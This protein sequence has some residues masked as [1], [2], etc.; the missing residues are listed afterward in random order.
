MLGRFFKLFCALFIFTIM[1]APGAARAAVTGSSLTTNHWKQGTAE[2][3]SLTATVTSENPPLAEM[4]ISGPQIAA[5]VALTSNQAGTVYTQTI[6]LA[7]RPQVGDAYTVQ[8]NY[9]TDPP[10]SETVKLTVSAVVDNFATLTAPL[11]G[12]AGTANPTFT[13]QAPALAGL[14][15]YRLS[16]KGLDETPWLSAQLSAGT[17]S[18]QYQSTG[19]FPT[20]LTKGVLYDWYLYAFDSL[21]NSSEN[22]DGTVMIGANISGT[23]TDLSGAPVSGAT[24]S[25][26]YAT[27][28]DVVPTSATT[29]ADGSYFLGGL[30]STN[31]RLQFS[32]GGKTFYYNNRLGPLEDSD[33]LLVSAI[34]LKTGIDAKL[35]WGAISGKVVN[36]T[37]TILSGVRVEL[38]YENG[39]ATS[40]PAATSKS[41]GTFAF[42]LIPPGTYRIRVIGTPL[43]YTDLNN[44]ISIDV[45]EGD[46]SAF[47][48]AVLNTVPKVN[49]TGT[50]TDLSGAPLAG[51]WVYP[52]FTSGD[53]A[54]GSGFQTGADGSYAISGLGIGDYKVKFSPLSG[55]GY[56][57]QFYNRKATLLQSD[58]ITVANINTPVTGINAVLGNGRP[59]ITGFT[60]PATSSSL[61]VSGITLTATEETYG[62]AGY[63]I[64]ES[65]TAPLATASGWT[66]SAPT[67]YTF[68][69]VGE[70]TLYAWAKGAT[71]LVSASFARSVSVEA[72]SVTPGD[73][74]GD[75]VITL[76]EVKLALDMYLGLEAPARFV[77]ADGD[78]VVTLQEVQKVIN[79][80]LAVQ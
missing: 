42:T 24:V 61:T 52:L 18:A 80:F 76:A 25:I 58:T 70:K 15:G 73:S 30:T 68:T 31:F 32:K 66:A 33:P 23:V 35:G 6:P 57:I 5:P 36:S 12:V 67:S 10:T 8:V 41:D 37:G 28:G 17:L 56:A 65:P 29:K 40:D 43:G 59:V 7:A 11:G 46:Y 1:A 44:G 78:D 71:G 77:D 45:T 69:G 13:W 62:V 38:L 22:R 34:Q 64:T 39:D 48:D 20:S 60:V 4:T 72:G 79:A 9:L 74:D 50:V 49:I 53:Y 19:S 51:I 47:P 21:G 16:I 63:L 54:T 27:N 14:S 3:Y 26:F 55:S 75:G 2:G